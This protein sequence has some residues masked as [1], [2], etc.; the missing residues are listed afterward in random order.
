MAWLPNTTL[1]TAHG[2]GGA[3]GACMQQVLNEINAATKAH[4][5]AGTSI[6]GHEL[7]G[8]MQAWGACGGANPFS[9]GFAGKLVPGGGR[10][11]QGATARC[12]SSPLPCYRNSITEGSVLCNG[13]CGLFSYCDAPRVGSWGRCR[14]GG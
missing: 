1:A 11:L 5:A 3:P 9:D 4:A 12:N 13:Y 8:L 10:R 2:V 14:Y 6:P 7:Q